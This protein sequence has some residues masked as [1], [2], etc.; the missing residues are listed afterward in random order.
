MRAVY[1][2]RGK[3]WFSNNKVP[4]SPQPPTVESRCR[5][6]DK[7]VYGN[8]YIVWCGRPS[9]EGGVGWGINI[10]V[11]AGWELKNWHHDQTLLAPFFGQFTSM[12][13]HFYTFLLNIWYFIAFLDPI[14]DYSDPFLTFFGPSLALVLSSFTK[15]FQMFFSGFLQECF[16]FFY[17]LFSSYFCSLFRR[18]SSN[19]Q[20]F[21]TALPGTYSLHS[22][23]DP[24]FFT[25]L[26]G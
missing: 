5:I 15:M 1:T 26:K 25:F 8:I 4:L 21:V 13:S 24:R 9:T 3:L 11:L 23:Q 6:D 20:N 19:T 16:E 17:L 10:R 18:L 2:Y 12:V 22:D 14:L 7:R